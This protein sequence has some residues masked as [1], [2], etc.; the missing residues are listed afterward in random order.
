MARRVTRVRRGARQVAGAAD[1]ELVALE[2]LQPQSR[3]HAGTPRTAD[4][5]LHGPASLDSSGHGPAAVV[6]DAGD[7]RHNR[8]RPSLPPAPL[9]ARPKSI[10]K[11]EIP[12]RRWPVGP[13]PTV[14]AVT[15]E[16]PSES[17]FQL[18][19]TFRE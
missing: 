15:R 8:F 18:K 14:P 17:D 16:A 12:P 19:V 4:G 7:E 1:E 6:S 11:S 5:S 9:R 10:G 13:G 2:P 3:S